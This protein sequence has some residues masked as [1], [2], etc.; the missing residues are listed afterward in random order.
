MN[1]ITKQFFSK[2]FKIIL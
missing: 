1:I 2:S